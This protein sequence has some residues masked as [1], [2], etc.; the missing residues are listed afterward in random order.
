MKV[1]IESLILLFL[2]IRLW[3]L[4]HMYYFTRIKGLNT[5]S[6][7]SCL[8]VLTQRT[9]I[10]TIICVSQLDPIENFHFNTLIYKYSNREG[11]GII[12]TTIYFY[13]Y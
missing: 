4:F 8:K 5:P 7:N 13:S 9:L 10:D 6:T 3:T 2:P 12:N 11:R 1:C